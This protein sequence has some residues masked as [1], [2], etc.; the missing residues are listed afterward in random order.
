MSVILILSSI[1]SNLQISFILTATAPMSTQV[2][3]YI[4]VKHAIDMG[5]QFFV[6]S[7]PSPFFAPPMP[8]LYTPTFGREASSLA[9][10]SSAT[11]SNPPSPTTLQ[12]R[13]FQ[14][15][16][17]TKSPTTTTYKN[18]STQILTPGNEF[19]FLPLECFTK[20]EVIR[21]KRK[22]LW[23]FDEQ[24]KKEESAILGSDMK[25]AKHVT[26]VNTRPR[27]G[28]WTENVEVIERDLDQ[29]FV[30]LPDDS[31]TSEVH[32]DLRKEALAI[33]SA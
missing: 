12:D 27:R 32:P 31:R 33:F 3:I 15:P 6:S 19:G 28:Y 24:D 1:T 5:I 10:D 16:P 13:Q 30:D 4:D 25:S 9:P 20:V 7:R 18:R 2:L 11:E 17:R 14:P 29:F 21:V 22:V 8:S 23:P 26:T